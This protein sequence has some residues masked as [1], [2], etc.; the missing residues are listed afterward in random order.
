M[1]LEALRMVVGSC[2]VYAVVAACSASGSRSG[3]AGVGGLAEAGS[4]QATGGG[5]GRE[6]VGGML[7][8]GAGGVG[9]D[10]PFG[11][12]PGVAGQNTG[13]GAGQGGGGGIMDPV[14]SAMAEPKDGTRL[15]AR[16]LV[17]ADGS[18]QWNYGWYDSQRG[19]NCQFSLA[20]DGMMRCVPIN[21]NAPAP[22]SGYF[23]DD[24]CTQQLVS[25]S[26]TG[27]AN[28][29]PSPKSAYRFGGACGGAAFQLFEVGA[30]Y[31]GANVY[32][33]SGVNCTAQTAPAGFSFYYLG[34]EIP[35]A[36]FVAATEEVA[37]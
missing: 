11:G 13:G 9:G 30:A 32:T 25:T 17:G 18:R 31:N 5:A 10:N 12:V 37:Q 7:V 4:H 6:G 21:A 36:S 22:G 34:N 14:P 35:A 26:A 1:R 29:P 24:A 28:T 3:S 23:A 19:E 8:D 33:K 2:A 27:C 20:S 16:Y 15:K